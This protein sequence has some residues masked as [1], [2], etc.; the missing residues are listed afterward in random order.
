ML[1]RA[2]SWLL[3]SPSFPFCHIAAPIKLLPVHISLGLNARRLKESSLHHSVYRT[4]LFQPSLPSSH[5]L[6]LHSLAVVSLPAPPPCCSAQLAIT[7]EGDPRGSWLGISTSATSKE[8]GLSGSALALVSVTE[9][10][11]CHHPLELSSGG[12]HTFL[13]PAE[14]RRRQLSKDF[15]NGHMTTA[16]GCKFSCS[17]GQDHPPP[18]PLPIC[19]RAW[20]SALQPGRPPQL[21][22]GVARSIISLRQLLPAPSV[23][24]LAA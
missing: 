16:G 11:F 6:A 17:G 2:S 9:L 21:V 20:H 23:L 24:S 19:S 12:P 14:L 4:R 3:P 7:W 15:P 5:S 22:R 13:F 18:Q 10:R 1:P 8:T